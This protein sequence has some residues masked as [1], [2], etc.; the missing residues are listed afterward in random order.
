MGRV[1]IH[2]VV[3]VVGT[4]R[5]R[6][7]HHMTA[8]WCPEAGPLRRQKCFGVFTLVG[9]TGAWPRVLNMWEYESWDDLA[10]NFS[11]E[12]VGAAHRDP[13]LADWWE[14]AASFR[15]GGLDRVLVAHDD[16]PGVE[17]WATR[18]GTGAVAYLHEVCRTGVGG[19]RGAC[20]EVM[21]QRSERLEALGLAL[22]GAFRTAMR[23]DDELVVMA[24][25]PDWQTWARVEAAFDAGGGG[26]VDASGVSWRER[27]LLV[28]AELSP[29][30]IGRQPAESDRLP[31]GT[32]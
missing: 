20:E 8:N 19:A 2:E 26:L 12:L 11:V 1:Y 10:H 22:V 23:A 24:A 13:M 27:V 17:D 9:S 31:L 30:R 4:E 3:D 14:R 21:R 29:L 25:V 5:A 7:Q 18:G 28:D 6:Y 15:S 32:I 16:S